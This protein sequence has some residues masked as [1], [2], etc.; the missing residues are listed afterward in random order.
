MQCYFVN[1][2]GELCTRHQLHMGS[3][4]VAHSTSVAHALYIPAWRKVHWASALVRFMTWHVSPQTMKWTDVVCDQLVTPRHSSVVVLVNASHCVHV[5]MVDET[6]LT[7]VMSSTAVRY[8]LFIRQ[9][10]CRVSQM[11][12]FVLI[13]QWNLQEWRMI[14]NVCETRVRY[15]C[16]R[17]SGLWYIINLYSPLHGTTVPCAQ[18]ARTAV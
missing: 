11:L 2:P 17:F 15:T 5:V 4:P 14:W 13:C 6:V 8:T 16:V 18:I 12:I 1:T 3:S 10:H 7:A 9:F